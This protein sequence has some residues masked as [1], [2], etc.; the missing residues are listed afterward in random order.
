MTTGH[1]RFRKRAWREF[2]RRQLAH[3]GVLPVRL[4]QFGRCA[5][6]VE[7]GLFGCDARTM[8]ASAEVSTAGLDG[9]LAATNP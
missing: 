7:C 9:K 6:C 2:L 4:D 8:G 5:D 1:H 3:E